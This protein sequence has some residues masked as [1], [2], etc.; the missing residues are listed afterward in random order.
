MAI[1]TKNYKLLIIED[2]PGDFALIEDF[3][4]EEIDAPQIRHCFDFEAAREV[5]SKETFD[6]VLLDLTL[7]DKTGEELIASVIALIGTSP[8]IVL[9]GYTDIDFSVKSLSMGVADYLLKDDLTPMA[10]YKSIL[11]SIE[12]KKK[13]IELQ[14]SEKHSSNLFNFSPLPMWV[15]DIETMKFLDVNQATVSHYGFSYDEFSIMTLKDIRP[16]QEIPHLL[17]GLAKARINPT[18]IA[19]EVYIHKKKSGE[20]FNVK[21]Q[22]SP[23]EHKGRYANLVIATDIT[24]QLKHVKAIEEQNKRLKEISWIQSHIIRAPLC[25][26]MGLIPL[27]EDNNVEDKREILAF[28]LSSAYELDD[29]IRKITDKSNLSN[30]EEPDTTE[31]Q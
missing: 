20:L 19:K 7:P 29:V 24:E 17:E 4:F 10:L 25:R 3:L 21:I 14:L 15:M 30:F 12:R 11:Y 5:L 26:I 2:N 18:E 27:L 22:V 8:L 9:T 31:Q 1:D 23:I 13:I 28:I 6:I 16:P